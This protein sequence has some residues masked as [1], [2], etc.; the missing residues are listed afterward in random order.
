MYTSLK[1][2]APKF[3]ERPDHPVTLLGGGFHIKNGIL[4]MTYFSIISD[5]NHF[6]R[7]N[8]RCTH[9]YCSWAHLYLHRIL[10]LT[11]LS[12]VVVVYRHYQFGNSFN[13]LFNIKQYSRGSWLCEV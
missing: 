3:L 12:E 2:T 11:T 13:C 9:A 10:G 8:C 7:I 5:T 6:H 1:D 4:V